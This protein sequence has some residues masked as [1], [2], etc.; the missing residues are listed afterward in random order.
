ME[1][2]ASGL[3]NTEMNRVAALIWP[4]GFPPTDP[5][6]KFFYG[7]RWLGPDISFFK[8]LK[9]LQASRTRDVMTAWPDEKQRNVALV[10]GSIIRRH[11]G[12]K[13]PY[14]IPADK[15]V[16]I[17]YGPRLLEFEEL[18]LEIAI[19]DFED[20]IGGKFDNKFWEKVVD[21]NDKNATFGELI[22]KVVEKLNTF[23]SP[24]PETRWRWSDLLI[25]I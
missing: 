21:W 7:V 4:P 12:W 10:F 18:P 8:E 5:W 14:F 2:G 1:I 13:T 20:Q 19:P 9:Q 16:V 3:V 22:N 23:N 15:A 6:K 24:S 11:A 17:A 25:R